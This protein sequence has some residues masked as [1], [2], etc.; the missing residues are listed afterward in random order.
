MR[1]KALAEAIILQSLEDLW[2]PAHRKESIEF[3]S[4]EGFRICARL[5][6]MGP[7]ECGKILAMCGMRCGDIAPSLPEGGVRV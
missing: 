7:E 6:G 5:A 2:E 1:T 4:G 3:L